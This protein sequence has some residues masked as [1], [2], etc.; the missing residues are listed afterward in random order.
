MLQ[1]KFVDL[2]VENVMKIICR[3]LWALSKTS[4]RIFDFFKTQKMV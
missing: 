2:N 3:D 4:I 1:F